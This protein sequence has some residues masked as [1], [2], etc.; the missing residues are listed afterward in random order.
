MAISRYIL[1]CSV[2][3]VYIHNARIIYHKIVVTIFTRGI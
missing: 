3:H 1:A 2:R